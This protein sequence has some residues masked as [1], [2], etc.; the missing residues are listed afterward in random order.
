MRKRLVLTAAALSA[1][2]LSAPAALAGSSAATLD[3]KK[4]TKLTLVVT[5]PAQTHD[6]TLVTEQVT[7]ADRLQC[8]APRC[9]FLPFVYKPAKGVKG[10]V[11]FTVSWS[12]PASD[13][14]LYVV[15]VGK[16][17]RSKIATC[18]GSI[19]TTEKVFLTAD[20]FKAG[21][22]Y[23]VIA[24]FYRTTGEKVTSTVE[25]PGANTVKTTVPSAVDGVQAVNCNL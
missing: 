11:A 3:G 15:Q 9:S 21:K 6:E 25:M 13:M 16:T 24:D 19:G 17:G 4:T 7:R 5:A 8:T 23:G 20:N 12:G 18:G 1:L 2:A 10:D 22:T 14:D